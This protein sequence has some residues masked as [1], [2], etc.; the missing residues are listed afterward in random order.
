[1]VDTSARSVA[2]EIDAGG[3]LTDLALLNDRHLLALDNENH[4][5]VWLTGRGVDWSLESRLDIPPYPIRMAVDHQADRCFISSLWS[6]AITV[7][8]LQDKDGSRDIH[9]AKTL[10]VSFEPQEMC[11]TPDGARL[12]VASSF[13]NSLAI[14]DTDRM[15]NI[16]VKQVP[17]HNIRGLAI[18]SNGQRVLMAQQ[19]LN[20]LGRSTRDDVHWGNMVSNL[21]AS[22][23]LE[24]VVGP[25]AD[26]LQ[27][28]EVV[29][30]GEPGNA[31]G[32]PGPIEIGPTGSLAVVLSGVN[33]LAI[34]R[35]DSHNFERI[36]VGRR[37]S[38]VVVS[39]DGQIF[40][41]DTFS[42]TISVL[43]STNAKQTNRITLGPQPKLSSA[44][45]GEMLFF[46]ARL[47]HDGWMSCHSCHTDGHSN[48]QL[49]DNLSDGSFD[50]PKRVLSLLGVAQTGPWAWNGKVATLEEQVTNSIEK[51][52]QG[53]SPPADDVVGLVAYL[54]TLALP[55]LSEPAAN[56]S[57]NRLR[58]VA[59]L[60]N[61]LDCQRCHQRPTYT[62]PRACDV[63][64]ADSVGNT[65]FNPPS[66]RA[67]GRRSR[68][69]H[70]GQTASLTDVL[71]KHRHQLD[72]DL[73]AAELSALLQFL[74]SL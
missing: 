9:V 72:R 68:L 33:E 13:E 38:A 22:F 57:A 3:R 21:I 64:L 42:D 20:S 46:D 63:G 29:F 16:G 4:Q 27:R 11:L 18:S 50:A 65:Q 7:V 69:F 52:M 47:S 56:G 41:A 74:R 49:N 34:G 8:A 66:L 10:A 24:D 62:S 17:G 55:P 28:R 70:D 15:E 60:F 40:V 1:V 14:V 58:R 44:E 39:P 26:I 35:D 48:G 23:P 45:L 37:P 71:K 59:A 31:A 32:D 25:E 12:I 19:E 30:L 6:Q 53:A 51:T 5:L 73:S 36:P 2:E 67:V 61:A 54:Q 43:D